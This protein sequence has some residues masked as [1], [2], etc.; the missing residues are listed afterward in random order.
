MASS[1]PAS[2]SSREG[3][4][5]PVANGQDRVSV[6]GYTFAHGREEGKCAKGV[7]CT[8]VHARPPSVVLE[9]AKPNAELCKFIKPDGSGCDY[10]VKCFNLHS[11]I[12]QRIVQRNARGSSMAYN[13]APGFP[14]YPSSPSSSVTAS[15]PT[16][17]VGSRGECALVIDGGT[18]EMGFLEATKR[19]IKGK[20][21][22]ITVDAIQDKFNCK[23]TPYFTDYFGTEPEALRG[24]VA[25]QALG[26]YYKG[27]K[28]MGFAPHL[29]ELKSNGKQKGTDIAIARKIEKMANNPEVP[30]II[31]LTGDSD[32]EDLLQETKS[33]KSDKRKPVFLVTWKKCLNRRLLPLV[34][35]VLYLDDIF[36]PTS[37]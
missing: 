5:C 34:R 25:Q 24:P 30:A 7:N 17:I 16:A 18:L 29:S 22:K 14:V 15:T 11:M 33:E 2:F 32:F 6:Q 10:G 9:V 20:D 31:L 3:R 21:F 26:K 4:V 37:E 12:E 35:E 27:I 28:G 23:V 36:P 8:Y 13:R 19:Y 1:F